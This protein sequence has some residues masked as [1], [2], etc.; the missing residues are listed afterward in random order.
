[1]AWLDRLCVL[2]Q[3]L[4]SQSGDFPLQDKNGGEVSWVLHELFHQVS[5]MVKA[6]GWFDHQWP[7]T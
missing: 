4:A 3:C 2:A 7:M 5:V 1:M 6:G